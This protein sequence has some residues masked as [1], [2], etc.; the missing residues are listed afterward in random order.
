MV[1]VAQV[2]DLRETAVFERSL[3]WLHGAQSSGV[4]RGSNSKGYILARKTTRRRS[5]I[6]AVVTKMTVLPN[7]CQFRSSRDTPEKRPTRGGI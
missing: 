6:E 4:E 2:V 3:L 7:R 1:V 5:P